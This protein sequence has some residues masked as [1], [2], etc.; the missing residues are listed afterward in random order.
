MEISETAA[1]DARNASQAA[2]KEA[3]LRAEV[4]MA[5]ALRDEAL[6]EAEEY[7]RKTVLLEEQLHNT[8][9]KLAHA[10]QAKLKMERDQRAN[11]SLL[12]S[13]DSHSS[14]ADTEYYKRKVNELTGHIQGLQA[15]IAEKN[16]QMEEMRRQLERNVSQNRM[17]GLRAGCLKTKGAF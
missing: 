17:E 3:S 8:K 12:K 5:T 13:L 15:T 16:R 11:A 10:T 1:V 4:S 7:K 9:T 14:N 6:G 2:I